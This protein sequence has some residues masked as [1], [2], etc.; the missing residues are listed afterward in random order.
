MAL[1]PKTFDEPDGTFELEVKGET[2]RFSY[3]APDGVAKP[4]AMRQAPAFWRLA[5][6]NSEESEPEETDEGLVDPTDVKLGEKEFQPIV[7]FVLEYIHEV[8]EGLTVG[9]GELDE[10]RQR[11]ILR[12]DVTGLI[13]A[14][15]Q[16]FEDDGLGEDEK[17]S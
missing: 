10:E 13:Q 17:K 8:E 4:E 16:I 7:D 2:I 9:W 5:H 14:Y 12:F 6:E 3:R 1:D 11:Q 15:V